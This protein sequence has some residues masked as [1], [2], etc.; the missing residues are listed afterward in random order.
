MIKESGDK[1][2]PQQSYTITKHAIINADP[3]RLLHLYNIA[4]DTNG[5]YYVDDSK[6][7]S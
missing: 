3:E 6:I 7:M 2:D 4:K 1:I 5:K